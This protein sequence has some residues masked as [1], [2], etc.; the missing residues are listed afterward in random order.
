MNS[1]MKLRGG[2][3][4]GGTRKVVE[5]RGGPKVEGMYD[6]LVLGEKSIWL[7]VHPGQE[8]VQTLYDR[9]EKAIVETANIWY[10]TEGHWIAS[11]NYG[12]GGSIACTS[13]PYK[14]EPCKGCD[15]EALYWKWR[16]AFRDEHGYEPKQGSPA[17]R[18]SR[19]TTSVVIVE[20]IYAVPATD[21]NGMAIKS[22]K[23]GR[24]IF[25]EVPGP[26]VPRADR[27]SPKS[28]GKRAFWDFGYSNRNELYDIHH[29]LQS[30]CASCASGL[31][32]VSACC[33]ECGHTLLDFTETPIE[34]W[35]DMHEVRSENIVCGKCGHEGPP[36]GAY[37]CSNEKCKDPVEGGLLSF[38]VQIRTRQVDDNRKSVVMTDF[39]LP[40]TDERIVELVKKPL[41][42]EAIKAPQPLSDQVKKMLADIL[43]RWE[44]MVGGDGDAEGYGD[45]ESSGDEDDVF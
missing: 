39:R 8:Y 11:L 42:I 25:N 23:T 40:S 14:S 10:Q 28:Y 9:D 38:E 35:M 17:G 44:E 36:E 6:R 27:K 16:F 15:I 32:M 34:D 30:K 18:S 26:L 2:R 1:G 5:R 29:E 20:D 24:P 31:L 3:K 43:E 4:L 21:R 41:D 12:R 7:R 33:E 19:Y 45:D 22:Q 37:E 13:G